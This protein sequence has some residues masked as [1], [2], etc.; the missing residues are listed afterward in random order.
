MGEILHKSCIFVF[1]NYCYI[2]IE[3]C[4][5]ARINTNLNVAKPQNVYLCKSWHYRTRVLCQSGKS[6]YDFSISV[7]TAA[8]Q[9]NSVKPN[10]AIFVFCFLIYTY[11]IIARSKINVG[12]IASSVSTSSSGPMDLRFNHEFVASMHRR[13]TAGS[14]SKLECM[15]RCTRSLIR[16]FL[17]S[18]VFDVGR[19]KLHYSDVWYIKLE[20][21]L[22]WFKRSRL[23]CWC[24]SASTSRIILQRWFVSILISLSILFL[25]S[26]SLPRP[27]RS[28]HLSARPKQFVWIESR[29]DD[30]GESKT[31]V[32]TLSDASPVESVCTATFGIELFC[33]IWWNNLDLPF[34][35]FMFIYKIRIQWYY[36][37]KK[38]RYCASISHK[39]TFFINIPIFVIHAAA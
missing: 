21:R 31:T 36:D 17:N 29:T 32:N 10:R 23:H 33:L 2:I 14:W 1:C 16:L 6:R 7:W 28:V 26:P 11:F 30:D 3:W 38:Y 15:R 19:S 20:Q 39:K 13:V 4:F 18:Y 12:R 35:Y 5:I 34:E 9:Y 25:D 24:T 27:F 8:T 37:I 22:G